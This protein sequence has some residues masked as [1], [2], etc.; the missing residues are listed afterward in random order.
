MEQNK[1]TFKLDAYDLPETKDKEEDKGLLN[2]IKDFP[3]KALEYSTRGIPFVNPRKFGE[4]SLGTD[5]LE[6]AKGL[7][8]GVGTQIRDITELATNVPNVPGY[9]VGGVSEAGS[10]FLAGIVDKGSRGRYS[11]DL[12]G[13][14]EDESKG[15]FSDMH[16]SGKYVF[17]QSSKL[18]NIPYVDITDAFDG[19]EKVLGPAFD[20]R[21][22]SVIRRPTEILGE[23]VSPYAATKLTKIVKKYKNV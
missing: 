3:G 1:R 13:K 10:Q 8:K 22:E 18:F 23:W 19:I 5:I 12:T 15:L 6:G 2:T 14:Y 7:A 4:K 11:L 9:L 21:Y 20:Q 17:D 16:N